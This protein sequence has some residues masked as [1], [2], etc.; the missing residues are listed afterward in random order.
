MGSDGIARAPDQQPSLPEL[1]LRNVAPPSHWP[2]WYP[3]PPL[4]CV[5]ATPGFSQ[6]PAPL[7]CQRFSYRC[8]FRQGFVGRWLWTKP[9]FPQKPQFGV[10]ASLFHSVQ[11]RPLPPVRWLF[12]LYCAR[13]LRERSPGNQ[14]N[15]VL[16]VLGMHFETP[17]GSKA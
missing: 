14:P 9:R 2:V 6:Q 4:T 3:P 15:W 12:D 17:G 16:A 7:V 5:C 1:P 8:F 13:V 10:T 11:G